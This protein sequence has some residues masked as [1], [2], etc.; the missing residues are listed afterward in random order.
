MVKFSAY[1]E[2]LPA[3]PSQ[4]PVQ[5]HGEHVRVVYCC[6]LDLDVHYFLMASDEQ[7]GEDDVFGDCVDQEDIEELT[8]LKVRSVADIEDDPV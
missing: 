4:Q 7:V 1:H 3:H 2:F 8:R 6:H 5:V